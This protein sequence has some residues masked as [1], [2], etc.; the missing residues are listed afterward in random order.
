[1]TSK[2]Q[3]NDIFSVTENY[4]TKK[5]DLRLN[6]ISFEV[7]IKEKKEVDYLDANLNNLLRELTKANININDN[8]MKTL[9]KSD[10]VPK[11][12]PFEAYFRSI[13]ELYNPTKLVGKK[14]VN[15]DYIKELT[16]FVTLKDETQRPAFE[17][18]FRK[19]L[20]R[21]VAC[22]LGKK[23]NKQCFVLV[24]PKQNI[25]KTTFIKFLCPPSLMRYYT[26]EMSFDKDGLIALSSNFMINLDE[27][28]V[29]AKQDLK[30][31]KTYFS[32]DL[33]KV[34]APYDAKAQSVKRRC[35]FFA[36]TND[37]DFLSD[38]T[39]SVRWVA[40]H[41]DNIDFA[42]SKKINI[43]MIWAQ[44]YSLYFGGFCGELTKEDLNDNETRN[45]EFTHVS[46]EQDYLQRYCR[47]SE[48]REDF[49]SATEVH[50]LLEVKSAKKLNKFLVSKAI[51]TLG[52]E[53]ISQRKGEDNQPIWGYLV[54][55]TN[56]FF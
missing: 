37:D 23:F 38:P 36:S 8:K 5:Y 20:I 46:S 34:R 51:K 6:T 53:R 44:A 3:G 14:L 40:F 12:D 52:Y 29:I 21:C 43:D 7:E 13:G 27:L 30:V 11:Y 48:S 39:G 32:K 47:K 19:M 2:Q 41:I 33:V 4:L 50:E 24:S 26:E 16:D 1:M 56:D 9:V 28:S 45:K 15:N 25:G 10:Y 54:K 18:M 35:N 31:L 55:F 17:K 22:S 49:Y 42:Y